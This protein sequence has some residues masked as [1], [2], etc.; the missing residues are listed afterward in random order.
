MTCTSSASRT[1]RQLNPSE[2]GRPT[3]TCGSDGQPRGSRPTPRATQLLPAPASAGLLLLGSLARRAPTARGARVLP[4]DLETPEVADTAVD[5]HLL[6]A[7][8]RVAHVGIDVGRGQLGVL[9]VLPIALREGER[10]Q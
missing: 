7:L 4:A 8:H 6:Q 2:A 9:A 3:H 10:A 1:G 5:A